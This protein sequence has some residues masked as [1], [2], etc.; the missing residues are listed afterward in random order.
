LALFVLAFTLNLLL[1]S[2]MVPLKQV[3]AL[4]SDAD[5]VEKV[6]RIIILKNRLPA[7]L[8]ATLAGAGL[9]AAGLYMQTFFRNPVAGPFILGI[10]SGSAL[11][12][13]LLIL[14]G[15]A[16]GFSFLNAGALGSGALIIAAS[17]GSL[18][19]FSGIYALS[20]RLKDYVVLLIVGLMLSSLISAIVQILQSFSDQRSLQLFIIWTFGGFRDIT[21]SQIW[22][23]A[24]MVLPGLGILT[25][26]IKP[27]NMLLLG[28]DQARGMGVD[29]GRVKKWII[30]GSCLLAAAVTAFCGPIGFIGL[31]VP[32]LARGLYKTEDHRVL[33][34]ASILYG[35]G[36]AL[37]CNLISSV[38]GTQYALPLNA[39]TA[40]FGA[41]AVVWI[42]LKNQDST[43]GFRV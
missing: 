14:G 39:V 24:L 38:P 21:L 4:I 41:P 9:S 1:G 29:L 35:A 16:F 8:A 18:L 42:I 31:A 32:H 10:S 17:L 12:V 30:L 37:I 6:Y 15:S 27:A 40:I 34:P 11:G 33:L 13:S 26:V 36:I 5:S 20:T 2:V 7:A 3:L 19:V 28:E 25:M 23:F 43:G 22:P